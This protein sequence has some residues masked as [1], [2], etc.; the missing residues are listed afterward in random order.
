MPAILGSVLGGRDA[1]GS[2]AELERG[3]DRGTGQSRS[4]ECQSQGQTAWPRKRIAELRAKGVGWKRI[5]GRARRWC[6]DDP[7]TSLHTAPLL[8]GS[9]TREKVF[10]P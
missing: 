10:W 4:T 8:G 5:A 9:K 1:I 2:V 6:R 7:S 3:L